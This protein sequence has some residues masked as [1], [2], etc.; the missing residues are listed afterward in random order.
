MHIML[1]AP[2]TGKSPGIAVCP[3]TTAPRTSYSL[4]SKCPRTLVG[5]RGLWGPGS[6]L[7]RR[8][9]CGGF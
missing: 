5:P 7:G 9:N 6:E 3:G 1:Q 2:K 8:Q 4:R